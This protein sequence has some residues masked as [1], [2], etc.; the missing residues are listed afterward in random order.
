[1][2]REEIASQA[3]CKSGK[4]LINLLLHQGETGGQAIQ[5]NCIEEVYPR[6]SISP[7]RGLPETWWEGPTHVSDFSSHT[8]FFS[9]GYALT[10]PDL[11]ADTRVWQRCWRQSAPRGVDDLG[12]SLFSWNS[13]VL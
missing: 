12:V 7:L 9:L 4:V 3:K 5:S 1:M 13:G 10:G 11:S 6:R 2:A 8:D